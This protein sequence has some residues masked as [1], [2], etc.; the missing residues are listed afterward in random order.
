MSERHDDCQVEEVEVRLGLHPFQSVVVDYGEKGPRKK[1]TPHTPRESVT[2]NFIVAPVAFAAVVVVDAAVV[3]V[4]VPITMEDDDG[5]L[6]FTGE[7]RAASTTK[8]TVA[9]DPPVDA[10]TVR[11]SR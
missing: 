8:M 3:V 11:L 7:L 1:A 2:A 4:V 10:A 5:P 9:A 6:S